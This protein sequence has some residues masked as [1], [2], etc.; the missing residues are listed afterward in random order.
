MASAQPVR[1]DSLSPQLKG[2]ATLTCNARGRTVHRFAVPYL[3]TTTTTTTTTV[4]VPTPPST[5]SFPLS[6]EEISHN[7]LLDTLH[8]NPFPNGGDEV[9]LKLG[10]NFLGGGLITG[11]ENGKSLDGLDPSDSYPVWL[12]V[13]SAIPSSPVLQKTLLA[14]INQLAE[15]EKEC[16]ALRQNADQ[17]QQ[18]RQAALKWGKKIH[19]LEPGESLLMRTGWSNVGGGSGHA[20]VIEFKRDADRSFSVVLYTST[21]YQLADYVIGKDKIRLKPLIYYTK[22]PETALL[23]NGDHQIRPVFIQHIMELDI[24]P[25]W[26]TS[27]KLS[28]EDALEIFDHLDQYR[29]SI[30]WDVCGAVTGQRGGTCAVSCVQMWIRS[31]CEDLALY[32]Q[33]MLHVKLRLFIGIYRSL[34]RALGEESEKGTQARQLLK[35]TARNLLRRVAKATERQESLPPLIDAELSLAA[36]ATALDALQRV[37]LC[38]K[39]VA[40]Q[41]EARMVLSETLHLCVVTQR[42]ARATERSKMEVHTPLGQSPSMGHP[43]PQ[44]ASPI[45]TPRE[46]LAAYH[47]VYSRFQQVPAEVSRLELHQLVDQLPIPSLSRTVAGNWAEGA[48][49]PFW[50]SADV[51]EMESVLRALE[52]LSITTLRD[53]STEVPTRVHATAL[54]LHAVTHYMAA[55]I[56]HKKD[57]D[58][59]TQLDRF[60][61]PSFGSLANEY[62]GLIYF[63][64]KEF[65]RIQEANRYFEA[66]AAYVG[67]EAPVLFS[68]EETTD[69]VLF[70]VEKAPGNGVLWKALLETDPALRTHVDQ[71]AD[72]CWPDYTP[73]QISEEFARAQEAYR[74]KESHSPPQRRVNLPKDTKR[75]LLLE[76][77]RGA[78]ILAS[79]GY[80][81]IWLLR[82]VTLNVHS[83]LCAQHQRPGFGP[84][85]LQAQRVARHS[86]KGKVEKCPPLSIAPD[87]ALQTQHRPIKKFKTLLKVPPVQR[88]MEEQKREVAE[89]TTLKETYP[90]LVQLDRWR[91]ATSEW[92]LTPYQLIEECEG[93]LTRLIDPQQQALFFLLFFRAPVDHAGCAHMGAG[94]LIVEDEALLTR[95]TQFIASGLAFFYE[96]KD[97]KRIQGVQFFLEFAVY[98]SKYL[99]DAGQTPRAQQIEKACCLDLWLAKA[100]LKA[101]ETSCLHHYRALLHLVRPRLLEEAEWTALYHSWIAYHFYLEADAVRSPMLRALESK[102]IYLFTAALKQRLE[103][104]LSFRNKL[105]NGII[106]ALNL[107][108]LPATLEWTY[109]SRAPSLLK[110]H[111]S[112]GDFWAIDFVAGAVYT[113]EGKIGGGVTAYPWERQEDFKRLFPSGGG[114]FSY[115]TVGDDVYTFTHPKWGAFRILK[116]KSSQYVIQRQIA[117]FPGEWFQYTSWNHQTILTLDHAYWIPVGTHASAEYTGYFASLEDQTIVYATTVDGRVVERGQL[118]LL[119]T[120]HADDAERMEGLTRFDCPEHILTYRDQKSGAL[121]RLSYPRYL[122]QEGEALQFEVDST[123]RLIWTENRRYVLPKQMPAE[124]LGTIPNYLYLHSLDPTQPDKI[125]VPFQKIEKQRSPFPGGALEVGNR[126]P[127][128]PVD[129]HREGWGLYRYFVL[130]VK[131]GELKPIT[132]ESHLFLAYLHFSQARYEEAIALIRSA[133][134]SSPICLKILRLIMETPSGSDHPHETLVYLHARL[135]YIHYQ[136]ETA[137]KKMNVYFGSSKQNEVNTL[138]LSLQAYFQSLNNSAVIYRLTRAQEKK[139]IAIVRK[140]AKP[141]AELTQLIKRIEAQSA[142][143]V[144]GQ[145]KHPRSGPGRMRRGLSIPSQISHQWRTICVCTQ[146]SLL[147]TRPA[148]HTRPGGQSLFS[149]VYKVAKQGSRWEKEALLYQLKQWRLH[150]TPFDLEFY[151]VLISILLDPEVFPP[152]PNYCSSDFIESQVFPSLLRSR[153]HY[154]QIENKIKT[155]SSPN[156]TPSSFGRYPRLQEISFDTQP[157]SVPAAHLLTM[158]RREDQERWMQLDSWKQLLEPDKTR[159]APGPAFELATPVTDDPDY[160]AS[161]RSDF[162]ALRKEY[163]AGKQQNAEQVLWTLPAT[164]AARLHPEASAEKERV[165]RA[166]IQNKQ[167]LIQKAHAGFTLSEKAQIGGL[168]QFPI[169]FERCVAALLSMD[170]RAYQRL[171]P[172]LSEA[173]AKEMASL[174]LAIEGLESYRAQ[175]TR[176]IDLVEKIGA[177]EDP[178]DLTRRSLCQKLFVELDSRFEFNDFDEQTQVV[179]QVYAGETGIIPYPKQIALLKKMLALKEGDPSQFTNCVIQLI[180]GGGKTSVLATLVLYLTAVRSEQLTLFIVPSSL[181]QTVQ[182]NISRSMQT[183]FHQCVRGLDFSREDLTTYRLERILEQLQEMKKRREPLVI[184]ATSLQCLELELLSQARELRDA[185]REQEQCQIRIRELEAELARIDRF[186]TQQMPREIIELGKQRS[187]RARCQEKIEAHHKKLHLL[188]KICRL[189]KGPGLLDEVDALLDAFQEVNFPSGDRIAI[190]PGTNNLIF[191]I[192]QTLL[193]QTEF[194]RFQEYKKNAVQVDPE[195]YQKRVAHTLAKTL[196]GTYSPIRDQVSAYQESFIRYA[197]GKLSPEVQALADDLTA[198]L[199]EM[200]AQTKQDIEFLRDLDRRSRSEEKT[201]SEAAALLALT[202]HLI[203]EVVPHALSMYGNR[204]FGPL[205]KQAATVIVPFEGVD[206]PTNRRFGYFILEA[207]CYY[208]WYATFPVNE[209]DILQLAESLDKSARY[210]MEKNREAYVDTVEY[211]EFLRMTGVALNAIGEPGMLSQAARFISRDP[212]KRLEFAFDV[213]GKNVAFRSERV[214]S[215]GRNLVDQLTTVRAMSGTPWNVEGYGR[216]LLSTY[217]PQ[218][219]AEGRVIDR[220]A[221]GARVRRVHQVDFSTLEAF[222]DQTLGK[223]P[224]PNRIRGIIE[225]GGLFKVFRDNAEVAEHVMAY[226]ARKQKEGVFDSSIEAVLFF[227]RDPGQRQPD[228]LYAWK[229]G[230]SHPE[231]VGSTLKQVF[232]AKGLSNPSCYFTLYD[233]LHTLGMDIEQPLGAVFLF[234]YDE[235]MT[236]RN[237]TQALMRLRQFLFSQD[238]EMV[239][240]PSVARTLEARGGAEAFFIE[241]ETQQSKHKTDSMVFHFMQQVNA[242]FRKHAVAQIMDSTSQSTLFADC[243]DQWEDFFVTRSDQDFYRLHGK[244]KGKVATKAMLK[245]WLRRRHQLF[246]LRVADE[247]LRQ[248]VKKEVEALEQDIDAATCLP[249]RWQELSPIGVQQEV[250]VQTEVH[251]TEQVQ[252]QSQVEE[253]VNQ[254]LRSYEGLLVRELRPETALTE[255]AFLDLLRSFCRGSLR[256]LQQHLGDYSYGLRS[257]RY[258]YERLFVEAIFGTEGYFYP[259]KDTTTLP[260]FHRLQRPPKQ[261]LARRDPDGKMRWLLLS[262]FEAAHVRAHLEKLIKEQSAAVDGVWLI[263]LDGS[264]LVQPTALESLPDTDAV[265]RGLFE[266]N[267]FAGNAFYLDRHP[268][269]FE[270]WLADELADLKRRYLSLR[271]ARDS[272]YHQA[273]K[274]NPI[275]LGEENTSP[276]AQQSVLRKRAERERGR[277][278]RLEITSTQADALP[279]SRIHDLK[280][281]CVRFLRKPEQIRRLRP[282]HI[283]HVTPRQ[284]PVLLTGQVSYLSRPEQIAALS[285]E[286]VLHLKEH[287]APLLAFVEPNVYRHFTQPWQI[288]AIPTEHLDAVS[289]ELWRHCSQEQVKAMQAEQVKGLPLPAQFGWVHGRFLREIPP[290]HHGYVCRE[291]IQEITCPDLIK[292]LVKLQNGE[293][294]WTAWVAPGRVCHIDFPTQLRHLRDFQIAAVPH[295]HVPQLDPQVQV[296]HI[297]AEQAPFLRGKRQVEACPVELVPF[298]NQEALQW[299]TEMHVPG[300][301]LPQ[302]EALLRLNPEL[303]KRFGGLLTKKQVRQFKTASLL[304]FL[305]PEQT[306]LLSQEQ[307]LMLHRQKRATEWPAFQAK[308][309]K[310]QIEGFTTK[311]C[312]Q[313]IT[314]TQI[315]DHLTVNQVGWLEGESQV[316]AIDDQERFTALDSAQMQWISSDQYPLV[317]S[318][319]VPGLTLNQLQAMQRADALKIRD[320]LSVHQIQAFRSQGLIDILSPAQ[321]TAHLQQSQVSLLHTE[322]QVRA[323]PTGLM[324]YL[325]LGQVTHLRADQIQYINADLVSQFSGELLLKIGQHRANYPLVGRVTHPAPLFQNENSELA[326]H[327]QASQ[328]GHFVPG[329]HVWRQITPQ[330]ISG[331]DPT[332]VNH[333]AG[334]QFSH[335]AA[336]EQIRAVSFKNVQ[337]LNR[338]QLRERSWGQFLAY[339]VGVI[340]L[341]VV[342]ALFAAFAYISLIPLLIWLCDRR[343]GEKVVKALNANPHRLYRYFAVYG[344]Q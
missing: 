329:H 8:Q 117:E 246:C 103:T 18:L 187:L 177:L 71:L 45:S 77:S 62:R 268:D 227:H 87:H 180:M 289:K 148:R 208:Q 209:G 54:A 205:E 76:G 276:Q 67:E 123:G 323:C 63:D 305:K 105:G 86:Y 124:R 89:A 153:A 299:I 158:E 282:F 322:E 32:K 341:G 216:D 235:K 61:I 27:L 35:V 218:E 157:S 136:E 106:Q 210:Y 239:V 108:V 229:K 303:L 140:E 119:D 230:A 135:L 78:E 79:N 85:M 292:A 236:R 9:T 325:T 37:T 315:R 336:R 185:L 318:Q 338:E 214:A 300:L 240:T 88:K 38:E 141:T 69:V 262:E 248:R 211:Q 81:Y 294:Q 59:S 44:L 132:P 308:I 298:L 343:K 212:N 293:G 314:P 111:S 176:I 331:L 295:Q 197:S 129:C 232:A 215:N 165:E 3:A 267:V 95:T 307:L 109:N 196:V 183:A 82:A 84:S 96:S 260:V 41:K 133:Q 23:F 313:L 247:A 151:D 199:L 223:H 7:S 245:E 184:K 6:D 127:M 19:A 283:P 155:S 166:L 149:A 39:R 30:P 14:G 31:Q 285:K 304:A 170:Y 192:Y 110:A 15:Y 281:D 72:Q 100:D 5:D 2:M 226:I 179:L 335:L 75:V 80:A 49:H 60:G 272:R 98:L 321:I 90:P 92:T 252:E 317:Q 65:Q 277:Q 120:L 58:P 152:L 191:Q 259:N 43:L 128:M 138:A 70:E 102:G 73:E 243:V 154:S 263:Q 286:Q 47:Q 253:E 287:Q 144:K 249:A 264:L 290:E 171:N 91:R 332:L 52:T 219:G 188:Q 256:T 1:S 278:G 162:E 190:D 17:E 125:V 202:R 51:R 93:E 163:Q 57:R 238:V 274:G 195:A 270:V 251:V 328:M 134:V 333:L 168:V 316:Q 320:H 271:T 107:G 311:E 193:T 94:E 301:T 237:T 266:L 64:S 206:C 40:Q 26:N 112:N 131:P 189:C 13:L 22:V 150:C 10:A 241:A 231:R 302:I 126:E 242:L 217:I 312:L 143:P 68:S 279:L 159:R 147:V 207:C 337:Y 339:T 114:S 25:F 99:N 56:A 55:L 269:V 46:F 221:T 145:R 291:Q 288:R 156:F 186:V 225:A 113:K 306:A 24:L 342:S 161:L 21:G 48:Q 265:D 146:T 203:C 97:K 29:V 275:F 50:Q 178:A 296:P 194:V 4:A 330:T 122:S 233:D 220:F 222:L 116:T 66:F 130:N 273:L 280:V 42:A 319:Q 28:E 74:R 11:G 255:E 200:D 297:T 257:A 181:Y 173:Q 309:T 244:I 258:H 34:E 33:L 340:T 204:D 213:V 234:T 201:E 172:H 310:E 20:M 121:L 327:L 224:T 137:E 83:C 324:Q 164:A 12:G 104:S 167:E 326:Q 334:E 139:L 53:G 16:S 36:Q 160:A 254:E 344:G 174:T 182:E 142:S 261:I 101:Q 175:L 228:T 284:I 115:L 118:H 198:S 250:E 169:T